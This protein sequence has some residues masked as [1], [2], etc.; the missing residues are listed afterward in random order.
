MTEVWGDEQAAGRFLAEL[1]DVLGHVAAGQ[2]QTA[3]F[4]VPAI[5]GVAYGLLPARIRSPQ[6]DTGEAPVIPVPRAPVTAP[7]FSGSERRER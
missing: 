4:S 7:S 5:Y 1:P 6:A 3:I 2:P